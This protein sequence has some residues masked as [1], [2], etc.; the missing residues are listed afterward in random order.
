WSTAPNPPLASWACGPPP[1][2]R[3][4]RRHE[5]A[6]D[7]RWDSAMSDLRQALERESERYEFDPA[8]LGKVYERRASRERNRRIGA[9]IVA[10][11]VIG[12]AAAG[13][14]GLVRG[15]RSERPVQPITPANV[16]R[17]R[18]AWIA[19]MGRLGATSPP[20]VGDGLVVVTS[21][22][23]YAFPAACHGS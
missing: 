15:L 8:L 2:D 4:P 18:I 17:L 11:V 13:V 22:K 3:W 6:Y 16:G 9:A 21:D 5:R 10:L 19:D 23:L 12:G 7:D 1:S 14:A 20:A